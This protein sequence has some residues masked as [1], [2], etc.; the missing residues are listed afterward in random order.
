M[1]C[2]IG[3]ASLSALSTL[4]WSLVECILWLFTQES[5]STQHHA[6]LFRVL[7]VTLLVTTDAI[8][9]IREGNNGSIW[10]GWWARPPN[11]SFFFFLLHAAILL[12][13]ML[14]RRRWSN[15]LP[16]LK[17][18]DWNKLQQKTTIWSGNNLTTLVCSVNA[19]SSCFNNRDRTTWSAT[20]GGPCWRSWRGCWR[21]WSLSRRGSRGR[22]AAGGS[23]SQKAEPSKRR[24]GR[25][26][27][28]VHRWVV[29][30]LGS[31]VYARCGL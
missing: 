27:S 13:L 26:A 30:C 25:R 11:P 2:V 21:S 31:L 24:R 23:I 10:A 5:V 20:Q 14:I 3:T 18:H 29:A 15:A 8:P 1:D 19:F 12:V 9:D 17:N 16:R 6:I 22:L 4:Q 7:A 28:E